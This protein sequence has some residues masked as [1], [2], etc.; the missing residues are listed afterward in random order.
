VATLDDGFIRSLIFIQTDSLLSHKSYYITSMMTP[1]YICRCRCSPIFSLISHPPHVARC[2]RT[3]FLDGAWRP[4]PLPLDTQARG[5]GRGC[6]G[7]LS[8]ATLQR[9]MAMATHCCGHL[10]QCRH[11][12]CCR[13]GDNDG[14]GLPRPHCVLI[15]IN[16]VTEMRLIY[17]FLC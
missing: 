17:Q 5:R 8:L 1:I 15:E 11:C 6:P 9:T 10:C 2:L 14:G 13:R 3:A 16:D 7:P 4:L 12:R